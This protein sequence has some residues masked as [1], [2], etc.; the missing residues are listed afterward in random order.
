MTDHLHAQRPSAR[1][2]ATERGAATRQGKVGTVQPPA[3]ANKRARTQPPNPSAHDAPLLQ[4]RRALDDGS[5]VQSRLA[6]ERALNRHQAGPAQAVVPNDDAG[7]KS[8][9]VQRKPNATGLPDRLKAGVEQLSG[10][11]MDDVRVHYNSPKP[12]SVQARAYTQGTDIHVGP[13]QE[14][15]L[16]HEAWH[17]V[18]QKQS[19]VKPTL[20][21]KG[22][23]INDDAGLELEASVMGARAQNN[24][25]VTLQKAAVTERVIAEDSEH[26]P[27]SIQAVI[28]RIDGLRE[29][30]ES[31]AGIK[32]L[33]YRFDDGIAGAAKVG[34]HLHITVVYVPAPPVV[35]PDTKVAQP[36]AAP[37]TRH[38]YH[39]FNTKAWRWDVAPPQA[40]KAVAESHQDEALRWVAAKRLYK[41]PEP[42]P[43]ALPVP[44][45]KTKAAYADAFPALAA[46]PPKYK[47]VQSDNKK[48]DDKKNDDKKNDTKKV[49]KK[50]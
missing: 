38:C 24:G 50:K 5:A 25:Q 45:T 37:V 26:M 23:A 49:E 6:L 43:A 1:Q 34:E 8:T 12:A 44:P 35:E 33:H 46:P 2:K 48:K 41:A 17:V 20:Q 16:P 14:Q 42:K 7:K 4:M 18:Q 28:Q 31:R 27:A 15:H 30:D 3:S 47:M 21:L 39:N 29:V 36:V 19:R 9:P 40:V 10:L 13:G 22:V 32:D 11:A